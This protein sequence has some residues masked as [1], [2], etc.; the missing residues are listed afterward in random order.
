MK[1]KTGTVVR[2]VLFA[3][4]YL[5]S[6]IAVPITYDQAYQ[7]GELSYLSKEDLEV[8]KFGRDQCWQC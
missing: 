5:Y 8:W 1:N 7:N 3:A 6:T 4:C 2:R